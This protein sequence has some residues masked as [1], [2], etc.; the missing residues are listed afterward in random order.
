MNSKQKF[1]VRLNCHKILTE[2]F[3]LGKILHNE[4]KG[5][6]AFL[7]MG[8]FEMNRND[9]FIN[10]K[11]GMINT[12]FHQITIGIETAI[13]ESIIFSKANRRDFFPI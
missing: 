1:Y 13:F 2:K 4:P 6:Y 5:I 8:A 3:R 9:I 10:N 12:G 7:F 11:I